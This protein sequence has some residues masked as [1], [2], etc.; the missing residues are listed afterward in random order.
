MTVQHAIAF[1]LTV[2]VEGVVAALIL[3][4]FF[5]AQTFVIQ[6]FTWP[7]AVLLAPMIRLPLLELGVASV[8][9]LL[10]AL[11]LPIGI[12]KAAI[13]SIA[14]NTVSALLGYAIF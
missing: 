7:L 12:R 6:L 9:T 14:A 8:E 11:V 2:G 3:R 4:R 5:W 10:W 1:A 13:V